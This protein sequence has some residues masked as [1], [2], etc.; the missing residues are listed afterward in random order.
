MGLKL[1]LSDRSEQLIGH[2]LVRLLET[3]REAARRP[4]MP[5]PITVLVPSTQYAEWLQ[6]RIALRAGV[7]MGFQFLTLSEHPM[8]SPGGPGD[9]LHRSLKAWGASA[10]RWRILPHVD[11][12]ATELGMPSGD[13]GI[14]PRDRLS[15]AGLLARH[16]DRYGRY[17]PGWLKAWASGGEGGPGAG[18]RSAD[19]E[20]QRTLWCRL[21]TELAGT[22]HPACLPTEVDDDDTGTLEPL[23]VVADDRIDPLVLDILDRLSAHGRPVECFL[24]LPTLG[25][26][27][28][29]AAGEPDTHPLTASLGRRAS[30][31]LHLLRDRVPSSHVHWALE[32]PGNPTRP[33]LLNRVQANLRQ[34]Y[35]RPGEPIH[36]P[37]DD[38][39]LRVHCCH[40]PRRELEVLRDELLRAFQ[41]LEGLKPHDILVGVADLEVYAPLVEGILGASLD[42]SPQH[43]GT[44]GGRL[45]VRL[46]TIPAREANPIAV[47]LLALL[48]LALGRRTASELID[49]LNLSAVQH[50]LGI[51]D[52]EGICANLGEM[53]RQVGVTHGFGTTGTVEDGTW[54]TALDRISAG[55]WFGSGPGF[56][57]ADGRIVLPLAGDLDQDDEEKLRFAAWMQGVMRHLSEWRIDV[58]ARE[59]AERLDGAIVDLLASEVLAD[60]TTAAGGLLGELREVEATTP[61]DIGGVLDWL[62]P[63]LENA[64]HRRTGLTGEIL[65]GR[66]DQ[67]HGL[68][69]RVLAILGLQDGAFPRAARLPAWDLLAHEPE[70]WD[71]D[72]RSQDQQRF[73]D[74]LLAP[75]DRLILLAANRSL[76]TPHDGPLSSCV[77]ELLRHVR[78]PKDPALEKSGT[79]A[80]PVLRHPIHPFSEAYFSSGSILPPSFNHP[81]AAIAA[82]LRSP[83]REVSPFF[84]GGSTPGSPFLGDLT[85]DQLIGF[86]KDPAKGWLQA[87]GIGL[88]DNEEDDRDLDDPPIDLDPL[89][90]YLV[91]E[92]ALTARLHPAAAGGSRVA[93]ALLKARRGLPPGCLGDLV[94]HRANAEIAELAE[95]I[96]AVLPLS[97]M[98]GIKIRLPCG[99]TLVGDVRMLQQSPSDDTHCMLEFR[100]GK[101]EKIPKYQLGALIRTAAAAVMLGGPVRCVV[102]GLD[103]PRGTSFAAIDVESALELLDDLAKGFREGLSRPLCFAPDTSAKIAEKMAVDSEGTGF[104]DP[105]GSVPEQAREAWEREEGKDSPPGEGRSPGA[106]LAWRDA[107]PFAPG[108][109]DD[110]IRWATLV[111]KRLSTWWATSTPASSSEPSP[112]SATP[113]AKPVRKGSADASRGRS[114]GTP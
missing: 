73:L 18:T 53:I 12:L 21:S 2:L 74:A 16:F 94:W 104:L 41:D 37:D 77:D 45:P 88:F 102:H 6:T 60:A 46:T 65:V 95:G 26:I 92:S 43:P 54:S 66:L 19:V 15:L 79:G 80:V 44:E 89:Q 27:R 67:I 61:I 76:R 98:K 1:V 100:P 51:A 105:A 101:Y 33:G 7:C 63:K 36:A 23:F 4:G 85:L 28:D 87:L 72:L 55:A 24:L 8:G 3:Q 107:D 14:P 97:S 56:D 25:C 5:A 49:L 69:C 86:W 114:G 64:T 111:S 30:G 75:T 58:S 90:N 32:P 47:G 29:P 57:L 38:G 42:S 96:E 99:E 83:D 17:R 59:W 31:V 10:L 22:P 70:P 113:K 109:V 9:P 84:S 106:L 20:W 93:G 40:S 13:Q 11:G 91:L 108:H 103:H 112:V 34:L 71:S 35:A 78:R 48:R 50:R 62:E 110:W 39:S 81:A 52:D 68:P 82:G